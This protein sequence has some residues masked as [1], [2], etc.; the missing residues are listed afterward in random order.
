[1]SENQGERI[2]LNVG[3]A[4]LEVCPA[5]G[6]VVTEFSW[7]VNG[8]K[9]DWLRPAPQAMTFLPT[10]SAS[11]PLVPISN[12]VREG[13]YVFEGHEYR[14]PLNFQP[15]RHAIHGRGWQTAWQVQ[16]VTEHGLEIAFDHVGDDW[17]SAYR[18]VQRFSLSENDLSIEM[19]VRNMGD[20]TMPAGLGPHPYFVRTPQARLTALVEKMWTSDE[21]VMPVD[22]VD[23]PPD[24]R[25][26]DGILPSELAMDGVF[27]GFGGRAKIAWP[28]WHASLTMEADPAQQ[29]LVVYTPEGEDF[30]CVE[31]V[32]NCTD[33]LTMLAEGKADTGLV[34]LAPGESL[35]VTTRFTPHLG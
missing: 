13:R 22:L 14:L 23:L 35:A 29:F 18:G 27:T 31:P 26:L 17:P 24:K 33:A 1:M 9:Y 5:Q 15:E 32:T 4:R 10:D 20:R 7:N 34:S 8:R 25:L 12:R 2:A 19:I 16:E 30:F 3:Q 11:F 28:E 6:G 21:E